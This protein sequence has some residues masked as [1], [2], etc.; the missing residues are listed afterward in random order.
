MCV[1]VRFRY[2]GVHGLLLQFG[3]HSDL[4]VQAAV[5]LHKEASHS[6]GDRRSL[7]AH[8]AAAPRD[9]PAGQRS[10]RALSLSPVEFVAKHDLMHF[11]SIN[12]LLLLLQDSIII[13]TNLS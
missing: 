11:Y 5:A 8:H 2:D 1:C 7:P 6:D 13:I 10:A 9:D 3:P 4:P 12:L